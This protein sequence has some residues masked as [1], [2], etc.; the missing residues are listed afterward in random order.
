MKPGIYYDIPEETYH[1]SPTLEIIGSSALKKFHDRPSSILEP[2]E[3]S[4]DMNLGSAQDAY[5][6]S[7]PGYFEKYFII[8][9]DFG[10]LR[11]PVNRK[12]AADFQIDNLNKIVLPPTVTPK[13]IPTMQAIQDVD[14]ALFHAHPL[15]SELL[16]GG[17]QQVSMFW[18]DEETGLL[19]KSRLDHYSGKSLGVIVDLK[20]CGQIDRF[21]GQI[22]F[23]RYFL[24]VGHYTEGAYRNGHE[25]N[26]FIFIAFNFGE[27][28]QIRVVFCMEDDY[29]DQMRELSRVTIR[30]VNECRRANYFPDF[31]IPFETLSMAKMLGLESEIAT[32]LMPYDLAEYARLPYE[33]RQL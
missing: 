29:L 25:I 15:S 24:Q 19:C 10:D 9:P 28:P 5:S 21:M 20:K 33:F 30:L 31:K 26:S 4:E 27:P 32:Q 7:G 11:N 8:R 16:R 6:L 17:K 18:K 12:K 14:N 3:V 1:A 23:L 13:K 2:T 22:N